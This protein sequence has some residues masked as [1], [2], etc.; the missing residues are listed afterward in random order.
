MPRL[1]RAE[2]QPGLHHVSARG[3]RKQPVFLDD[4]DRAR[5]HA[6]LGRT[7]VRCGW[8]CLAYCQMGNHVHLL[9]ETTEP[10]L[11]TGM[12]WLQGGYAQ[13]FNRRHGFS[14]HLFQDRFHAEPVLSDA[15]LWMAAVYIANNPPNAGLCETAR[16]WPWSSSAAIRST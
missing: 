15:H 1:A 2:Y 4:R 3:N 9:I 14:G 5:Y 13:Q 16:D 8:L 11:G 10:N 7:V 6:M 12:H